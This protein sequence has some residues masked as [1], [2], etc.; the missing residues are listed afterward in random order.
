MGAADRMLEDEYS[1]PFIPETRPRNLTG[2]GR[3]RGENSATIVRKVLIV[4]DNEV[5]RYL[6]KAFVSKLGHRWSLAASGEE[7]LQ[8]FAEDAP[9]IVLMDVLMPGMS[10]L[11]AT[12][13]IRRLAGNRWIPIILISALVADEDLS[14][15]LEAGA[16]DYLYKPIKFPY[17]KAKFER[18]LR[19]LN[20][21]R[22]LD[23]ARERLKITAS[24][25]DSTADGVVITDANQRIIDVNPSFCAMTGYTPGELIGQT[26]AILNSGLTPPAVFDDMYASLDRRGV[27][28]GE[29]IN[30]NKLGAIYPERLTITLVRNPHGQP[31]HYVGVV[32]NIDNL[33]N[34]V[35]TGLPSQ[36]VL[37]DRLLQAMNHA[38][39]S[40]CKVALLSVGIDRMKELNTT[41]GQSAGD[42][43]IRAVADRLREMVPAT[44]TLVR[45]EGDTFAIVLGGLTDDLFM[46]SVARA[47]ARLSSRPYPIGSDQIHVSVSIGIAV[48]PDD[49]LGCAEL[50]AQATQALHT[51]KRLGGNRI[52][53][54]RPV[55]QQ[56]VAERVRLA[57]DLRQ[58]L[59]T[60]TGLHLV[61][62]PI[63]SLP[64]GSPLKAEVLVR[65]RHP[66][67]GLISPA[68]FIPI[69]ERT[70]LIM[71]IGDW[72]FEQSLST[73]T[74]VRAI[75]PSFQMS[76]NV[77]PA[78]FLGDAELIERFRA[79]LDA[80]GL[81]A[82][83][84]VLELTEGVLIDD[85]ERALAQLEAC[86]AAGFEIAID[87][88]GTGYSSLSY[89]SQFRANYLKIDQSF[90]RP[91]AAGNREWALCETIVRM[92]ASLGLRVIAEGIET[93]D[94]QVLLAG[95][96]CDALQGYLFAQP[97]D[98]A[99]L[100]QFVSSPAAAWTSPHAPASDTEHQGLPS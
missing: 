99:A 11:D 81:P 46:T 51:A 16:E 96:S 66:E 58:S 61:F 97:M 55:M 60:G 79:R 89:L 65:W 1:L 42:Q 33:R 85:K 84:I 59:I 94:Q 98:E 63:L 34:D 43:L 45:H 35:L 69:A 10:G 27:W 93:L 88:F 47:H 53:Y 14:A 21:R 95:T 76:V 32:S 83:A 23:A 18:L 29:L 49:H 15:G 31:S 70:G 90:V 87:D 3:Q 57:E 26:P 13:R 28:S 37:T 22:M 36:H 19:T 67:K 62:Q 74:Q 17:F 52:E 50:L 39:A 40:K 25:F 6:L 75:A 41:F 24:V 82:S 56:A 20:E 68:S 92:G 100:L 48:F 2:F 54:F 64:D 12:R 30:R 7:A 86:H 44:D 9:D 71:D 5:N 91:I 4:D 80:Y 77:S 38:T 73:L 72:V 8:R 78:Q